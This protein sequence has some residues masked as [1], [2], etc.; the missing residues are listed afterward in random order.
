M[1]CA[2]HD[3]AKEHGQL[4]PEDVD[5]IQEMVRSLPEHP[6]HVVDLGAGFGTTAVSVFTARPENVTVWSIDTNPQRIG[7]TLGSVARIA[8]RSDWRALPLDA[9][10]DASYW[11]DW[12]RGVVID[13]LMLDTSHEYEAT[14]LELE[15]WLPWVRPGG[16][17]WLHD[18]TPSYPGCVRAIDEAVK[19][20]LIG[21]KETRGWSWSGVKA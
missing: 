16:L 21:H 6:V 15:A 18:Y 11:P 14:K 20:G 8:R 10:G 13:M 9:L 12:S 17:L 4:L 2:A 5:L 19:E 7:S 1:T 3:L